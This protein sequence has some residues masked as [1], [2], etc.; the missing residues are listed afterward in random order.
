MAHT[1][2]RHTIWIQYVLQVLAWQGGKFTPPP[3]SCYPHPVPFPFHS[4][5]FAE[6]I[7]R[8]VM[9]RGQLNILSN[10]VCPVVPG[11]PPS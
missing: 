2:S 10:G 4:P 1:Y 5:Q 11:V 6:H 9:S 3:L 7:S 8:N